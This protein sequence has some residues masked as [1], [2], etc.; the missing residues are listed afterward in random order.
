[1]DASVTLPI[2]CGRKRIY[3]PI[4]PSDVPSAMKNSTNKNSTTRTLLVVESNIEEGE[5]SESDV[6]YAS[7]SGDEMTLLPTSEYIRDDT[8]TV[9]TGLRK[10]NKNLLVRSQFHSAYAVDIKGSVVV[11]HEN[12]ASLGIGRLIVKQQECQISKYDVSD[13][14]LTGR[15]CLVSSFKKAEASLHV[16]ESVRSAQVLAS[17]PDENISLLLGLQKKIPEKTAEAV[18]QKL[19]ENE[20]MG[21]R[22]EFIG[23]H[24]IPEVQGK[25]FVDKCQSMYDTWKPLP[26]EYIAQ[27]GTKY[28]NA[29]IQRTRFVKAVDS[30]GGSVKEFLKSNTYKDVTNM[31]ELWK[32]CT[33]ALYGK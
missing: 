12:V 5:F 32:V 26:N 29:K 27:I 1:M 28:R 31:S 3:S 11:D 4:T 7:D 24:I 25:N 33:A 15:T 16:M 22:E 30:S 21:A 18:V 14:S 19:A 13:D 2:R 10:A 20:F 8:L 9:L 23:S 17:P 6:D